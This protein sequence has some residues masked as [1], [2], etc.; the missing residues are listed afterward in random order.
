VEL[1]ARFVLLEIITMNAS[2]LQVKEIVRESEAAEG[3][4]NPM[5]AER[6]ILIEGLN[7][8]MAREFQAIMMY[9]HYSAKVNGPFRREL[10]AL[11][12]SEIGEEMAHV[13][14][15][16]DKIA[17]LG[18][19]PTTRFVE[20]P[21]ARLPREMLVQALK[22]EIHAITGYGE[23]IRQ[24]KAF[25]DIGLRVHLE[26]HLIEE[27]RHKEEIEFILAGWDD[28]AAEKVKTDAR[29]QDVGGQG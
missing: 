19:D 25:G 17:A 2:Q 15:L 24:A 13:Q 1:E 21:S 8:D 14:F 9:I 10:R 7:Q 22:A 5:S 27:T 16:A 20:V 23:R 18:G 12:Q 11:F 28:I 4:K 29:W 6:Q 3:A 26:N